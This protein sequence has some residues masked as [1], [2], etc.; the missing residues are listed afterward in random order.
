MQPFPSLAR[1]TLWYAGLVVLLVLFAFVYVFSFRVSWRI[2]FLWHAGITFLLFCGVFIKDLKAFLLFTMVFMFSLDFGYHVVLPRQ[3]LD[4][5]LAEISAFAEGVRIDSSDVILMILY[6]H[7]AMRLMFE[8]SREGAIGLGKPLGT[9]LL[10][11]IAYVFFVGLLK[12]HERDMV[13]FEV[14]VLFR[15]FLFFLYLVNN[16][17]TLR[18]FRVVYYALLAVNV[19][20]A[21]LM[22]AQYATGLNYDIHGMPHLEF[23]EKEG[24]RPAGFIG[25]PNCAAALIDVVLPLSLAHFLVEKNR[26]KRI[27]LFACI[28]IML[29]GLVATKVRISLAA[30]IVLTLVVLSMCQMR[31][32]ISWKRMTAVIMVGLVMLA[33]TTPI[34]VDRFRTGDYGQDRLPLV[35]TA[36]NMIKGNPLLGVGINNYKYRMFE[37]QPPEVAGKWAYVVHNELLSTMAETGLIGFVLYYMLAGLAVMILWRLTRSRDPLIFILSCGLFASFIASIPQRI[38]TSYLFES[39]FILYCITLALTAAMQRFE[40]EK[41]QLE[42]SGETPRKRRTISRFKMGLSR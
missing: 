1:T 8:R 39:M 35:Y 29:A 34:M 15:G 9:V 12:A 41:E 3:D 5:A 18:D 17:I 26:L 27:G 36:L 20:Q 38:T 13:V 24:F 11:W 40:A 2:V 32:W 23:V 4:P 42:P 25:C 6:G 28:A 37:Y 22:L 10:T 30:V 31:G 14:I 21:L 16:L 7:W 19:F 33:A